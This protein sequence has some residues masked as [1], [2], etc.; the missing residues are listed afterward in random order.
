MLKSKSKRTKNKQD[1]PK[2]SRKERVA[3]QRK[4]R[5]KR[6]KLLGTLVAG[7]FLGVILGVPLALTVDLEIGLSL[8]AL[9]PC[10]LLSFQYPRLALWIFLIYMPFSGTV[11]YWIGGGNAA[12][13]IAKD[14]FYIPALLGLLLECRRKNQ[15][16][17]V[18]KQLL[19][20]LMFLLFACLLTLFIVNASQQFLPYC[21][22]LSE[23]FL[24]AEDGSYLLNSQGLVIK[25]PCKQGTPFLQGLL[26]LKVL[27]G[28][29]PLIF[30]AHY[31]IQ[32]RRRL[33]F[34]GRLLLVL[35]IIC[36]SLGLIQYWFLTSGRCAG[37]EGVQGV[38]LF[39]A[40]LRAKCFVGGALLYSPSQGE[41]RL[42][43][44]FV[45]PW[46]WAWF[47]VASSAI[48]FAVAFSDPAFRW[49]MGGLFGMA[50][51]FVNAVIS[52][53]RLA[54]AL[55]PSLILVLLFLT[56]QIVNLKRFIPVGIGLA[57]LL[58]IVAANNPEIIQSRVDS[59]VNRWNASPPHLFVLQQ[60]N[61]AIENQEGI[62]GRGLGRA[63]NSARVFGDVALIE[64]FHA[65]L[66]YEVGY[67]G[68]FAFLLFVAH[69]S[70]VTFL[71]HYSVRDRTLHSYGSC[72]WVFILV[73]S[74]FPYWYPLDT[75]PVAVYYWFFAGVIFRL[76]AIEKQ[77]QAQ[78]G[79]FP[80][81]KR[82]SKAVRRRAYR[83]SSS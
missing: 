31:L 62:L 2:L 26:G 63:T 33:L 82:R 29:I 60:L 44:T 24:R 56:G 40:S 55:V 18:A 47:L 6:K 74:F 81:D 28:Y 22:D 10:V 46:H 21:S 61:F 70:L 43:G 16:V 57:L 5:E 49:R 30:C 73:I 25:V 39:K 76:P 64:T 38:E 79:V 13:Q 75:D 50:I 23:Q 3:Q 83:P 78:D 51:V 72:L 17:L 12:F 52:G 4:A 80:V 48:C 8:I 42:P 77:E 34:L 59:F 15:P 69:L 1:K 27:I 37:T 35:A 58:G 20:T 32:D 11:T 68:L 45:S 36:C 19:P 54:L 53:Q 7:L 9:I 67:I 66:L 14:V 41:I 71:K 65:K